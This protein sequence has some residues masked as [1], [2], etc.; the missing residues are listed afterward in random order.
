M[1]KKKKPEP[2]VEIPHQ[3]QTFK[4]C[5]ACGEKLPLSEF[6][7]V[8]A[9]RYTGGYRY[10]AYCKKCAAVRNA[11]RRRE[12]PEGSK[13]RET[14]RKHARAY[15]KK[16]P[17]KNRERQARYR[18][19][20]PEIVKARYHEW[21]ERNPETRRASQKAWYEREKAK[22][23]QEKERQAQPPDAPSADPATETDEA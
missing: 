14:M 17:E 10:A 21:V 4:Y 3:E 18:E 11:K 19:R 23:Q 16:H 5:P 7:R 22:R 13:T 8:Q 2:P 1:S 6:Y 9:K 20:H 15:T 12:A